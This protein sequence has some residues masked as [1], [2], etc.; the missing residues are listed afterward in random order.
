MV[1][2]GQINPFPL[3]D[4]QRKM[5]DCVQSSFDCCFGLR[6]TGGQLAI[7]SVVSVEFDE[8]KFVRLNSK[9]LCLLKCFRLLCLK[10]GRREQKG[11]EH[12]EDQFTESISPAP[13]DSFLNRQVSPLAKWLHH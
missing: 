3:K 1:L 8:Q 4:A 12:S 9:P 2:F 7:L 5:Y 13:A 11:T 10:S 6:L